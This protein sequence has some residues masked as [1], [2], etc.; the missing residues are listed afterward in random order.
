MTAIYLR[1]IITKIRPLAKEERKERPF[2][3]TLNVAQKNYTNRL[4]VQLST[5]SELTGL[6]M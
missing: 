3:L 4:L 6:T 5:H 2:N 1:K